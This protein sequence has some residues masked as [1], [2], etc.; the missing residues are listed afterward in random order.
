MEKKRDRR[1]FGS[2]LHICQTYK[3]VIAALPFRNP[4]HS[5]LSDFCQTGCWHQREIKLLLTTR[6]LRVRNA[7]WFYDF[8]HGRIFLSYAYTDDFSH[9]NRALFHCVVASLNLIVGAVVTLPFILRIGHDSRDAFILVLSDFHNVL[10]CFT[11]DA[12]DCLLRSTP[13]A[14]KRFR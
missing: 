13:Y 12:L 4:E 6:V 1:L 5:S 11:E 14:V 3:R 7:C 8:G 9:G 10:D 2:F